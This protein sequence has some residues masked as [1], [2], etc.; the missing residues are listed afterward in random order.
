[1]QMEYNKR[2]Q[3]WS[4]IQTEAERWEGNTG[5]GKWR[6]VEG[7]Q[8]LVYDFTA[9]QQLY[10][11]VRSLVYHYHLSCENHRFMLWCSI[12]ATTGKTSVK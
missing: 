4:W 6:D 1:M 7:Y 12:S 2:Q 8:N 10:F 9:L 5:G 11:V 3:R